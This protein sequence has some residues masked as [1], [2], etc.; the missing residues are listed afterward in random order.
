MW[1]NAKRKLHSYVIERYGRPV[2]TRTPDL[3][4]VNSKD[5]YYNNLQDR[6]DCQSTRKSYKTYFLW[7]GLWFGNPRTE[8]RQPCDCAH[9]ESIHNDNVAGKDGRRPVPKSNCTG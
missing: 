7:V 4:R 1:S 6:G 8:L 5:R 2:G 9:G 3:Y